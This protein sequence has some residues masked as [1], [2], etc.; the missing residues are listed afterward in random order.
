[1]NFHYATAVMFSALFLPCTGFAISGSWVLDEDRCVI[2]ATY[3]DLEIFTEGRLSHQTLYLRIR[4]NVSLKEAPRLMLHTTSQRS[5]RP[6]GVAPVYGV[7]LPYQAHHVAEFLQENASLMVTYRPKGSL[8]DYQ[9]RFP[10]GGFPEA[11]IQVEK[12]RGR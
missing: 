10:L 3:G 12:C 11:V 1:M 9:A 2:R 5:L 7:E 8:S 6:E 4:S